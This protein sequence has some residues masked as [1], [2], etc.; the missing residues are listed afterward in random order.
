MF[1]ALL[2]HPQL[3]SYTHCGI[4]TPNLLP[5]VTF[6][7]S[8]WPTT[9]QPLSPFRTC[10]RRSSPFHQPHEQRQSR[11]RETFPAQGEGNNIHVQLVRRL[12]V[13]CNGCRCRAGS[14][15]LAPRGQVATVRHRPTQ[16]CHRYSHKYS[17]HSYECRGFVGSIQPADRT[18][19]YHSSERQNG[20]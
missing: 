1:T 16:S 12:S 10:G 5:V 6:Q 7:L 3:S 13:A 9:L 4:S 19:H 11:S 20:G 17:I 15:P 14:P 18:L 8:S 2:H